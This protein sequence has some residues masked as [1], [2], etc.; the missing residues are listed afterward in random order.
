MKSASKTTKPTSSEQPKVAAPE[1]PKR[2]NKGLIALLITIG[3]VGITAIVGLVV[4]FLV[5]YISPADYQKASQ[6]A[7]AAVDSYDRASAAIDTYGKSIVDVTS[8]DETVAKAKKDADAAYHDYQ[9]KVKDLSE[10][11]A[12][13]DGDVKAVYDKFA[14]KNAIFDQ[15]NMTMFEAMPLL[16]A[17][18]KDCSNDAIGKLDTDDLGQLVAS[19]DRATGPCVASLKNLSSA[20]NADAAKLGKTITEYFDTM[21]T[22]IVAMQDAYGAQDRA[23]FEN[24]YNAFLALSDKYDADSRIDAISKHQESLESIAELKALAGV[25][26][27]KD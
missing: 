2:S 6:Q 7:H 15:N 17:Y 25:L 3:V 11:R 18:V 16:R 10:A 9:T 14:A 1:G 19:F 4:F 27:D 23:K 5:M 22:H 20:K 26:D 21:R 12:L 8:N 24:E 13:R